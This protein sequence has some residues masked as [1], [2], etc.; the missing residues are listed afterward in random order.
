M[1]QT[2][3]I[4]RSAVTASPTSLLEGELAYSE[5]SGTK[6]LYIGT[7]AGAGIET[8]GGQ[9]IVTKVN[10]LEVGADVTNAASVAAAGAVMESDTTT[11]LMGFVDADVNLSA[12]SATKIPTQNAVKSYVDGAVASGVAYQGSYN[13]ATNTPD[14][15]VAP[16]TT[17]V[18]D[19]Y[20]VTVAGT[21]FT[22]AVEVGDVLIAEAANPTSE[23]QWTVVQANM[24]AA[25]IKTTYETNADTNAFTDSHVS[26]VAAN[27]AK[28]GITPTQ[29]ANIVTNN[30]KVSNVSTNLSKTSTT[31][32]VT[33]NSSD[34]ANIALG[35]ATTSVAG[36]MTKALYDNVIANN[37]KVS[38]IVQ[39]T[40]TGN[41]GSADTAAALTGAQASA[42]TANTAKVG[43]TPTQASN[44]TTNNAKVGITAGQASAISAN[45]A[46]ITYPSADS[47][48]LAGIATG[49]TANS[50]DA[51]LLARANHT[52]TQT[53]STISDFTTTVQSVTL[54]GGT[55]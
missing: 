25:T 37:A 38:N 8:I 48:K 4:K 53:A 30:A 47:T 45:T 17:D 33:V 13:A 12:N 27:S 49:A 51:V 18:G 28:V 29:A 26:A 9:D 42:I 36:V 1:A 41:A 39:T 43:I 52:G 35:A 11:A 7:N 3:R 5:K 21:F 31:T 34:G 40:I 10:G 19:M 23:A 20:T 6:L 32:N 54:D 2:I 55:F 22:T 16:A 15:D 24:T 46:K 44:I 50:T 14:L